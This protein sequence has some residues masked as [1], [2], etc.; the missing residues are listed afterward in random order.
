M[1][2]AFEAIAARKMPLRALDTAFQQAD[3]EIASQMR[4][5]IRLLFK[6]FRITEGDYEALALAL[7]QRHVPG[8]SIAKNP[9]GA[10]RLLTPFET[11]LLRFEIEAVQSERRESF[12]DAAHRVARRG[13]WGVRFRGSSWKTLSRRALEADLRLVK[14]VRDLFSDARSFDVPVSVEQFVR[15]YLALTNARIFNIG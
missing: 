13:H 10:K 1:E 3:A 8:F 12:G 15:N 4:A 7:A 6:H 5:K 14:R 11:A 9:P 2:R